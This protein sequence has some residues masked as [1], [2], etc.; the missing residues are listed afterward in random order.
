[1]STEVPKNKSSFLTALKEVTF[2][3]AIYLYFTGF[4]YIYFFYDHFGIPLRVVE[5]PVY[6]M[7]IYSY[8]VV[9]NFR[10]IRWAMFMSKELLWVWLITLYFLL[11]LSTIRKWT[12]HFLY[13]V[14][15]LALFPLLYSLA[16]ETAEIETGKIRS[17]E[18]AKEVSFV[19]KADAEVKK[20][21]I[22][23][24]QSTPSALNTNQQPPSEV[25]AEMESLEMFIEANERAE[26]LELPNG[27]Y[28]PKPYLLTETS[29]SFYVLY[30]PR[31]NGRAF[32]G[33]VY[34][35]P[36]SQVLLA[37]VSIRSPE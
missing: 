4:I 3:V 15:L 30:Q 19:F 24:E 1:M 20:V 23:P 22:L 35:I 11:L 18:T 16:S 29:D 14:F 10:E 17:G 26:D 25:S 31:L 9:W 6:Y 33:H 5:I 13:I 2:F 36:R 28:L 34:E 27:H 8:N 7:F 21:K 12:K 32:A 37:H